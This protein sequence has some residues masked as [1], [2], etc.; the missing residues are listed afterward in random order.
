MEK[1]T[2]PLWKLL[3]LMND[4]KRDVHLT[5]EECI[6]LL[7]YDADR[8]VAGVDPAEIRPSVNRH[9]ALCSSCSSQLEDWLEGLE[10]S[11]MHDRPEQ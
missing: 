1:E 11:L 4:S 9:L 6:A 3:L 10:D 8:L 2:R 5:R 7:E